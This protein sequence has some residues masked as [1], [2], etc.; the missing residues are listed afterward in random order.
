MSLPQCEAVVL[1]GRDTK[2]NRAGLVAPR[3]CRRPATKDHYC[4][5]HARQA[6]QQDLL[7][8]CLSPTWERKVVAWQERR[9]R[10][11]LGEGFKVAVGLEG[12]ALRADMPKL[13]AFLSVHSAELARGW[14]GE[15]AAE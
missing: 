9:Q 6:E 4:G 8:E 7:R 1:F 14:A 11:A 13:S 3:R 2:G 10:Q 5:V 12:L 15:T